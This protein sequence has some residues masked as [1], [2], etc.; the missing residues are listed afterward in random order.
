VFE[1]LKLDQM[2][3]RHIPFLAG[4]LEA[5]SG[6]VRL[7]SWQVRALCSLQCQSCYICLR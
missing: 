5:L 2:L 4:L 7:V 3:W 6:S 1:D